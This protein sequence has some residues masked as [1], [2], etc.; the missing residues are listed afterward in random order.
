MKKTLP[1]FPTATPKIC[2]STRTLELV[3]LWCVIFQGGDDN[4]S[5][6]NKEICFV[7]SGGGLS[8]IQT[9]DKTSP[10]KLSELVSSDFDSVG[11]GWL[12]E[13]QNYFFM[14]DRDYQN[15]YCRRYG[16]EQSYV[17][18]YSL[19]RHERTATQPIRK[20]RLFVPSQLAER[21]EGPNV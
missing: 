4:T 1:Q 18:S 3:T 14:T 2:S 20:G 16:F 12:T 11:Q 6:Q 15:L 9:T 10:V 13:D 7:S 19:R 17:I 21:N 5:Y 8:I